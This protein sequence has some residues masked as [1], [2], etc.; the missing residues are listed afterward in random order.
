MNT[1][2]YLKLS[3]QDKLN[4]ILLDTNDK[5]IKEVFIWD[6]KDKI[7]YLS[8]HG[9]YKK[10]K[11][12]GCWVIYNKNKEIVERCYFKNFGFLKFRKTEAI[13]NNKISKRAYSINN[14]LLLLKENLNESL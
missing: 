4:G 8:K 5:N 9:F 10:G 11:F 13:K 12:Y 1:I 7:I 14:R 2:D 3:R 6:K